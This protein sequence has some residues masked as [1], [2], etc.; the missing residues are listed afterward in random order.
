L[1]TLQKPVKEETRK[2]NGY[3][4]KIIDNGVYQLAMVNMKGWDGMQFVHSHGLHPA[5][6]E[7]TVIN[8]TDHFV[9]DSNKESLYITLMLWKKSGEKWSAAELMPVKK[10][11]YSK[12]DN[13]RITFT[14]NS[15]KNVDLRNYK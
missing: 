12:A 4:V 1:P 8:V 5:A 6:Y 9:P 14:D 11:D 3:E 15:T 13:L 10:L 7:S 2:L